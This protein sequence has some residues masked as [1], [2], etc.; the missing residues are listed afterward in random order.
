MSVLPRPQPDPVGEGQESV[1]NYPRPAIAEPTTRHIVIRHKD[2]VLADTKAA[3]RT[4]ETSH[5]PTYYIPPA[6]IAMKHF[7]SNPRRSLCEWKG[8]ASYFDVTVGADQ[9][10]AAAWSY[11]SPTSSFHPVAGYLAFYCEPFD[12]VLVDG[13]QVTPQ[14]GDFYGGW[15]TS[16]EVGPFK[17]IP[18]SWFW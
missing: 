18:G 15:I 10:Q 11:T 17:G 13:E 4:L 8:Q 5:P 12:E 1:W 3:Y 16:R 9:I 7:S 6:D 14:P 2:V